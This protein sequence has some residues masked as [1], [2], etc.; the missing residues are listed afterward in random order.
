[1]FTW[2]T[3]PTSKGGANISLEII[4]YLNQ[5]NSNFTIYLKL[6]CSPKSNYN[7]C[8]LEHYN[9]VIYQHEIYLHI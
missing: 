3:S 1:M 5:L 4:Y 9:Y 2:L 7:S 6:A 8:F